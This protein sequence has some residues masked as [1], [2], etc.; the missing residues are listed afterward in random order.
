VWLRAGLGEMP[1]W[2]YHPNSP[3]LVIGDL[4]VIGALVADQLRVDAPAG[5]VRAF[6]VRTGELVWAWDPVPPGWQGPLREGERYTRGTPNVWSLLSGDA[7]RGLVFVPMGNASPDSYGGERRGLDYYASSVVALD[8]KTGEVVWHF[9]T[10]HHDVWDYDLPARPVLVE[11]PG[12]GGGR[13]AVVV[14]TKMGHLFV[15]D[16]ETGEPLHPVEERPVPQGGVPGET[17]SATQPFPTRPASIHPL[18]LSPETA[19]GFTPID[20]AECRRLI[21]RHRYDGLFTPPTLEGSIQYPHSS[22]GMNW[23]GVAIDPRSGLLY[24]NQTHVPMVVQLI[25]RAEYDALD[26]AG[27]HYPIEYYPMRGTPYGVK[28]FGLFSS[29]GAPCSP[30]P[31]GSLSAVDLRSGELRWQVPLGTTRDQ[32]PFPVWFGLG[33]PNF[34][35]SLLT[36]SGLVFI[37]ATTD[38]FLR[39]FEAT[40][41]EEIWRVRLPFTAHANPISYR[42]RADARQFVVIAAGGFPVTEVGDALVAYALP[43]SEM[44]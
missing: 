40:S 21:A 31:W 32:A 36:A 24:T 25:P 26:T 33:T 9:Q 18:E 11:I 28:R 22:G 14:P 4:A 44:D 38:K 39:A 17:L 12:V 41:G 13:P 29:F 23:G 19:F 20:R 10:V 34:G 37:G 27:A 8:A 15:L 16:R 2:E 1:D 6:D 7:E 3:P 5:V 35:G 42:L 30:P 43:R